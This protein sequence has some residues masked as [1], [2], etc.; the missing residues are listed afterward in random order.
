MLETPGLSLPAPL[1]LTWIWTFPTLSVVFIKPQVDVPIIP[2]AVV[3]VLI[4]A[5]LVSIFTNPDGVAAHRFGPSYTR[6]WIMFDGRPS[7]LVIGF[8]QSLVWKDHLPIPPSVAIYMTLLSVSKP[9]T[10][11]EGSPATRRPLPKVSVKVS[12]TCTP[13]EEPKLPCRPMI[14]SVPTNFN[15]SM[16]LCNAPFIGLSE[17]KTV[18]NFIS[19]AGEVEMYRSVP[20]N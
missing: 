20:T 17:A 15:P 14:K 9:L 7:V 10:M 16:L 19:P 1:W 2:F 11:L 5:V 8:N 18:S 13:A 3:S 6:S 12:N 4:E